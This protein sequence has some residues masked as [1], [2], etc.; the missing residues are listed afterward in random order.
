MN[1]R[2]GAF[3]VPTGA[4]MGP[5]ITGL[6]ITPP[7]GANPGRRN[8]GRVGFL[9][10]RFR[11]RMKNEVPIAAPACPLFHAF[12]RLCHMDVVGRAIGDPIDGDGKAECDCRRNQIADGLHM[13]RKIDRLLIR[14][15]FYDQN[16][17]NRTHAHSQYLP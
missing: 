11:F 10:R 15:L 17:T 9:P 12:Q 5:S 7:V 14:R 8:N 3:I 2:H 4:R 6:P 1:P 13:H 16:Q